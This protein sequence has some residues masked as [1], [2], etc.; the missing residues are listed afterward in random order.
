[1]TFSPHSFNYELIL[2]SATSGASNHNELFGRIIVFWYLYLSLKLFHKVK[3]SFTIR[4]S[5]LFF[6]IYHADDGEE[7][8]LL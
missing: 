3:G 5:F 2:K 4:H 7:E 1:V 8:L 6:L